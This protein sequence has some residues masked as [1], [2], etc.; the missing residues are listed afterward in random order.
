MASINKLKTIFNKRDV[1]LAN[2]FKVDFSGMSTLLG[3]LGGVTQEDLR[4]LS[5]LVDSTVMPG[6]QLQTFG[7]DLFRHPSE[8]PTGYVNEGFSIE[9]NMPGDMMPKKV[10]DNWINLV[11]D[12]Q[13][14]LMKYASEFKCPMHIIQTDLSDKKAYVL[15]L[16]QVFPKT[17]R[18]ISYSQ[19]SAD[20]TK[21]GV[22]FAYN[23]IRIWDEK[24]YSEVNK[25]AW[26][27]DKGGN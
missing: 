27:H 20:L 12:S 1:A 3:N 23:D 16:D 21:F 17:I 7:Y 4:E 18:G 26:D 5:Y 2:R 13:T 8:V 24:R 10:F 6:R 9:F 15:E 22:E 11:V 14:Y 25:L 19:T